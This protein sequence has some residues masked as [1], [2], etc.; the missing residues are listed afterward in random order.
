MTVHDSSNKNFLIP[1]NIYRSPKWKR[2]TQKSQ[3]TSL[4]SNGMEY[5]EK[6]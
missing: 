6:D 4:L 3:I 1:I 2:F 5:K